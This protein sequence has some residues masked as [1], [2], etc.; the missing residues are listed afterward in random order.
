MLLKLYSIIKFEM[1][2]KAHRVNM[3]TVYSIIFS[4]LLTLLIWPF[5]VGARA[6]TAPVDRTNKIFQ[7]LKE[8]MKFSDSE[9]T[10]I[11][12]GE[13][14]T[15]L[16]NTDE[17]Q[18]LFL[19]SVTR[20][21]VPESFFLDHY[22]KDVS[23]IENLDVKSK[24]EIIGPP[25]LSELQDA[26]LDT[27]EIEALKECKVGKCGLKVSSEMIDRFQREIDWSQSGY[28][29]KV[30]GLFQEM[31]LEY[32]RAYLSGGDSR[33]ITYEDQ[34]QPLS[35]EQVL[36]NILNKTSFLFNHSPALYK[37][38][39]TFPT[40][41]P[42]GVKSLIYWT[43]EDIGAN[44]NVLSVNQII[45]FNPNDALLNPVIVSKQIYADHYFEAALG[46]TKVVENTATTVPSVYFLY[47]NRSSIDVLR[48][49][50]FLNGTIRR[51]I[52]SRLVDSINERMKTIK[53]KIEVLYKAQ[54]G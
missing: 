45:K 21:N 28:K 42:D 4:S 36:N 17:K 50:G 24:G 1:S 33:L 41:K 3:I 46:I 54:V 9:L 52:E 5:M 39:E 2:G 37:Y 49:D 16:I 51:K 25:K 44:H 18:E 22:G 8:E 29:D 12:E 19:V 30:N 13:L 35:L 48:R 53:D 15:K 26:K 11:K 43:K 38:L 34:S 6:D 20:I 32:I 23:I 10:R 31:L 14:T 7:T 47:I 40:G 27:K